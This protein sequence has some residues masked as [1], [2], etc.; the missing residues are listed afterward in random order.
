MTAA[1]HAMNNHRRPTDW[2][3]M[4]DAA[5]RC[6]LLDHFRP[7]RGFNILESDVGAW[8]CEQ[9]EV[10]QFIFNYVKRHEAIIYVDG[11]WVGAETY[12]KAKLR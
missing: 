8:L 4:L 7:G 3:Q 1:I 5:R 10:R 12:A 6:S 2:D 11:R 9:P